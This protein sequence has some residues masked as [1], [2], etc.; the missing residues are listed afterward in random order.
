MPGCSWPWRSP[1]GYVGMI[2]NVL[3]QASRWIASIVAI[4]AALIFI[5]LGIQNA[6]RPEDVYGYPMAAER[7]VHGE[8]IYADPRPQ[9]DRLTYRHAPWLAWL[10]VGLN[11][12][13]APVLL[14]QLASLAAAVFVIVSLARLRGHAGLLLAA[15]ALPLLGAVPHANV[16]ILM[17]ALLVWRRADPWSVGIAASLKIYPL[18]LC[19]GYIAERRWRDLATAVGLAGLLWLPALWSGIGD[20]V[21][22]PGLQSHPLF[23]VAA[24]VTVGISLLLALRRSRW[25]WLAVGAALP[26]SIPHYVGIEY[27]WAAARRLTRH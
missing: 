10:W 9:D 27:I 7:L 17:T 20:W 2:V 24:A 13:P 22:P 25:T 21:P 4:L 14:W 5:G 15:L 23:P 8:S 1:A 12:L 3:L 16:G 19:V 18:L 11:R 26:V 6:G